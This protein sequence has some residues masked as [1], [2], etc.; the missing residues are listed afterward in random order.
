MKN[1][2]IDPLALKARQ[3]LSFILTTLM[4]VSVAVSPAQATEPLN[5]ISYPSSELTMGAVEVAQLALAEEPTNTDP[6]IIGSFDTPDPALGLG[7]PFNTYQVAIAG[8]TAYL[9]DIQY[10]LQIIDVSDPTDP[11]RLGRLYLPGTPQGVAVAG[12]TAY[13]AARNLGLYI[14]DVSNPTAPNLISNVGNKDN[15]YDATKVAVAGNRAYVGAGL[16]QTLIS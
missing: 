15:L 5:T 16:F 6:K 10:G 4:W 7:Q 3:L 8:N 14:I 13:V 2:Q 1:W 11:S 9:A 12:N